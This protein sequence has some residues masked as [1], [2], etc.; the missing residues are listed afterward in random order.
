MKKLFVSILVLV[1]AATSV[2]GAAR[3]CCMLPFDFVGTISQQAQRAVLFHHDG[4][5]ELILQI[6]YR[7][8]GDS[9]PEQF[10]WVVTTPT[11]PSAYK[12]IEGE[13][14]KEVA[15]WVQPLVTPP[16][17]AS[18]GGCQLGCSERSKSADAKP[19]LL[20]FGE[21]A[22]VGPYEIQPVRA[23]GVEALGALNEW[24]QANGFPTEDPKHMEYFVEEKFTFLCIKISPQEGSQV[25]DASGEVPPLH[26]SFATEKIYYP[27][28]FS[29]RQGE[30]DLQLFVMS[31][32]PLDY[33]ASMPTLDRMDWASP[34]LYRN[35]T[36]KPDQ[37]PQSLGKAYAQKGM[38]G[39]PDT[40]YLN[41][42]GCFGV[43]QDNSIAQWK[44]DVF[45]V[46]NDEAPIHSASLVDSDNAPLFL[47]AM[48]AWLAWFATHRILPRRR[49]AGGR[50]ATK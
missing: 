8:E 2:P 29:S 31:G 6:D 44:K 27:L 49:R 41:A 48:L 45:L 36:V 40:W 22:V 5:Q 3:A 10:A 32:T 25:V 23:R 17:S 26:L 13:L 16:P 20:E 12:V 7:I 4:Q 46:T 9:T 14:F 19:E 35:V 33:K 24:L 28:M 34:E 11:E 15:E 39:A 21:P 50:V 1:L 47:L 43:N 30:F 18:G 37:F 42:I 38:A